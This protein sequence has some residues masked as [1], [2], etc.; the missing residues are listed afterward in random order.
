MPIGYLFF[1]ALNTP[2]YRTSVQRVETANIHAATTKEGRCPSVTTHSV[3]AMLASHERKTMYEKSG[4]FYAD[5]RDRTGQRKRKSFNTARAALVFESEQ[6]EIAHP[7]RRA[8]RKP[9][10]PSFSPKP[11]GK[12]GSLSTKRLNSLSVLRAVS[13]PD[14]SA[15]R[16][17]SKRTPTLQAKVLPMRHAPTK[18]RV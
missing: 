10:A 2:A 3:D 9:Y 7:K 15:P 1:M 13:R 6:K 4:K 12:S 11:R 18:P 5:W 17:P 14:N 16:T 8:T